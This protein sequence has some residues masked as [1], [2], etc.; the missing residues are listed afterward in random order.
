ME[1]LGHLVNLS[2][3]ITNKN[4]LKAC[5]ATLKVKENLVFT[6][7]VDKEK[8]HLKIKHKNVQ[9]TITRLIRKQAIKKRSQ[10]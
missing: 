2:D 7:M 8:Y 6:I 4:A 1:I 3:K 5:I 9:T 10:K